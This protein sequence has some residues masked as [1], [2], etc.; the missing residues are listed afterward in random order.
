MHDGKKG[1]H[2]DRHHRGKRKE[3]GIDLQFCLEEVRKLQDQLK[4]DIQELGNVKRS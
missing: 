1:H 3:S 2:R 4:K